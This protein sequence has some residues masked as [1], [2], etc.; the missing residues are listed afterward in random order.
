VRYHAHLSEA[1]A[2]R[3]RTANRLAAGYARWLERRFLFRADREGLLADL[4]ASY[5]RGGAEKLGYL[6]SRGW[7]G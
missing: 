6:G 3:Y 4:R 7:A 2:A 1:E 5:R